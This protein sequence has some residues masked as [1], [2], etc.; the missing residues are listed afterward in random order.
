MSRLNEQPVMMTADKTTGG[1]YWWNVKAW[2]EPTKPQPER[3]LAGVFKPR[4]KKLKGWQR[5][6]R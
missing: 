6:R 4:R 2:N 1:V 5:N 3:A